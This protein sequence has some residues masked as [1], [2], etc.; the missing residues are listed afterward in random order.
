MSDVFR[1]EVYWSIYQQA[2]RDT[3]RDNIASC[4]VKCGQAKDEDFFLIGGKSVE[5]SM[6]KLDGVAG[7]G[8]VAGL[9][10]HKW[11]KKQTNAGQPPWWMT[12][13]CTKMLLEP[14]SH[15][16]R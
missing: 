2:G 8:S 7:D 5:V 4:V 12:C 15:W 6:T 1:C 16:G 11:G 9:L 10:V 13:S 3:H 14:A